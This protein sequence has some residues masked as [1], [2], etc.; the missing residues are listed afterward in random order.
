MSSRRVG[1]VSTYLSIQN[2]DQKRND[3]NRSSIKIS[4][5]IRLIRTDKINQQIDNL[6]VSELGHTQENTQKGAQTVRGSKGFDH[7]RQ[8]GEFLA[9]SLGFVKGVAEV[10]VPVWHDNVASILSL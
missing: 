10:F 4:F 6:W 7:D 5:P 9:F 8:N 3:H 1:K 2:G